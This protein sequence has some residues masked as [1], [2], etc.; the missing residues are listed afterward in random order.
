MRSR[1]HGRRPAD[2]RPDFEGIDV[3]ASPEGT[4]WTSERSDSS[5][6][7]HAIL[8]RKTSADLRHER[9]EPQVTDSHV[10]AGSNHSSTNEGS[11]ELPVLNGPHRSDKSSEL[12]SSLDLQLSEAEMQTSDRPTGRKKRKD[13]GTLQGSPTE[14]TDKR[15]QLLLIL[16]ASYA[17]AVTLACLY[18]LMTVMQSRS[19]E[20]EN[21]PDVEPL[22][23]NE[24]RYAPQHAL[25]P[26]GHTLPLG[27]QQ[28]FGHILVEPLRITREPLEY[29]HFSGDTKQKHESTPSVLQLWVRFTNV[30]HD[31]VIVPLDRTLLFKREFDDESSQFLTN[32]FIR[33][34][35]ASSGD[36]SMAYILDHPLSSE[37]DIRNQHL[38]ERLEPGESVEV[39]LPSQPEGLDQLDGPSVWR[40]HIRKGFHTPTG[41]GVTTLV[42]VVFD[43]QQIEETPANTLTATSSS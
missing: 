12:P 18:L 11:S 24:F 15:R 27:Q 42:D 7:G 9:A 43:T 14:S 31:Q 10:L 29:V 38:G 3:Q 4:P 17:S 32:N 1:N 39:F 20:L 16:L 35:R 37:W 36:G 26:A 33:S 23:A 34:D 6:D 19:H 40:M 30:S 2:S 5:S 28:Q 21:L 8:G 25:L 41:H 13:A 22:E